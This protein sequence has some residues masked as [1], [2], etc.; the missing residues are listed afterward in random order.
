[1]MEIVHPK[2]MWTPTGMPF[3]GI[4]KPSFENVRDG[5]VVFQYA[6]SP[7][8]VGSYVCC[9]TSWLVDVPKTVWVVDECREQQSQGFVFYSMLLTPVPG[10]TCQNCVVREVMDS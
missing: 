7:E 10:I 6:K 5:Q 3:F 4:G 2:T 1:M 9:G 8:P